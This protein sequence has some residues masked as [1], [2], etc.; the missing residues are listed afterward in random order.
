MWRRGSLN[1]C[2]IANKELS[3]TEN[4]LNC[5]MFYQG[6]FHHGK[7]QPGLLLHHMESQPAGPEISDWNGATAGCA[8]CYKQIYK[9]KQRYRHAWIPW[10]GNTRVKKKQTTADCSIQNRARADWHTTFRLFDTGKLQNEINWRSQVPAV[11]Y[12]NR[13]LQIQLFLKD[14][15]S[16]EQTTSSRSWGSFSGILQGAVWPHLLTGIFPPGHGRTPRWGVV[17]FAV[18]SGTQVPTG[19][20]DWSHSDGRKVAGNKLFFYTS[21]FLFLHS[22]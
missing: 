17:S 2:I 9:H 5:R 14:N 18:G 12:I 1:G 15:A 10:L 3:K 22:S 19:K 20:V 4:T 21:S 8:I 6:I 13:L 16:V 7:V 11:L